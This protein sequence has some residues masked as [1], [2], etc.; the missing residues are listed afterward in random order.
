[1]LNLTYGCG[2]R[3][4]HGILPKNGK[5]IRPLLYA[6]RKEIED[7]V[8]SNK[9][10]YRQDSSNV[11]TKYNRNRLRQGVIP[12]LKKINPDLENTFHHNFQ[13]YRDTELFFKYAIEQF[14]KQLVHRNGDRTWIDI[15][16]VT[17]SPAPLT[18]LFEFLRPFNFKS[19][20]IQSIYNSRNEESGV[21]FSSK[22]HLVLRD[23][24]HWIVSAIIED[25]NDEFY[26]DTLKGNQG[27]FNKENLCIE[28]E[29]TDTISTKNNNESVCFD[30]DKI[31]FPLHLRHWRSGDVI[32]PKG[33]KGHKKKVSKFFKDIKMNR[34]DKDSTWLLCNSKEQIIWIIGHREDE[35]FKIEE[36]TTK[37]LHLL[38]KEL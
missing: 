5:I 13:H 20:K 9:F 31:D 18:L 27:V 19:S 38:Y 29:I 23:R 33:M 6:N 25:K 30:L 37:V 36:Q 2:I 28:W 17:S 4:L 7:Y 1:M 34:F 35:R 21:I 26:I 24:S 14:R 22:S 16:G 3:G 12:E 11:D 32:Y 15:E 8:I 10:E